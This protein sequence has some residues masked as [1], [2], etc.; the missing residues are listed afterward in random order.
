MFTAFIYSVAACVSGFIPVFNR[1]VVL[2]MPGNAS[3]IETE[4][5]E[6]RHDKEM[7][8]TQ[9]FIQTKLHLQNNRCG[10]FHAGCYKEYEIDLDVQVYVS[11]DKCKIVEIFYK[12]APEYTEWFESEIGAKVTNQLQYYF[13]QQFD[14][15]QKTL[16]DFKTACQ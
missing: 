1:Q 15:T 13:Q 11:T 9:G 3:Y 8:W 2:I 12:T 5:C 7:N 14:I 4:K 16:P 10:D 6:L